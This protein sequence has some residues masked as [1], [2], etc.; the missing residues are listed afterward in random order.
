MPE[1]INSSQASAIMRQDTTETFPVLDLDSR[2]DS[3][4]LLEKVLPGSATPS[5][6]T[7]DIDAKI[8]EAPPCEET[9]IM[10]DISDTQSESM[11]EPTEEPFKM[12]RKEVQSDLTMSRLATWGKGVGQNEAEKTEKPNLFVRN[13]KRFFQSTSYF[14]GCKDDFDFSCWESASRLIEIAE[15]KPRHKISKKYYEKEYNSLF[16]ELHS[17]I[18][19]LDIRLSSEERKKL[20]DKKERIEKNKI[21]IIKDLDRTFVESKSFGK[22]TEG[23]KQLMNTL[24]VLALKYPDIG[25]VQGMNF[26]V[27]AILNHSS[28]PVALGIMIYLMDNLKMY[29]IYGEG[30]KGVSFHNEL[31]S[32]HVEMQ[33]PELSQHL[34]L[35]EIN[36]EVFFTQWIL[37]LFSHIIPL[38]EYWSFLHNIMKHKWDFFYRLVLTMLEKMQPILLK[39]DDWGNILEE[40]KDYASK[41]NWKKWISEANYKF[42]NLNE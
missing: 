29:Y 19:T 23:R 7:A 15:N 36:L 12:M 18:N 3:R 41:V 5:S 30:L 13:F 6:M 24:E 4:D 40:I 22:D 28:P 38:S 31:L 16:Q 21:Q 32:K 8:Y 37:D 17:K 2:R 26:L 33:L 20:T 39:M 1:Y 42:L 11:E 14:W 25:Y 34:K 27:A 9:M 35:H 10:S